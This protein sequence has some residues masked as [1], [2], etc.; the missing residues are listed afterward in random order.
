MHKFM[1]YA[2]TNKKLVLKSIGKSNQQKKLEPLEGGMNKF[3][4]EL[5]NYQQSRTK[6]K[7]KNIRKEKDTNKLPLGE[8]GKACL[9]R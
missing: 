5:R 9:D 4:S 2:S 3:N 7:H 6:H 1:S 8:H